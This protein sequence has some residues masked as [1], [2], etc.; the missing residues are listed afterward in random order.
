MTSLLSSI[1]GKFSTSLVLGTLF[2]VTIFVILFRL[3]VVPLIPNPPELPA[4]S[5]LV[6]SDDKWELVILSIVILVVSGLLFNLNVPHTRF[7]EGYSWLD[8]WI[9][10]WKKERYQRQLDALNAQLE[11]TTPL[12]DDLE[13]QLEQRKQE[14]IQAGRLPPPPG[15]PPD[16]D[17][18]RLEKRIE[19]VGAAEDEA[20]RKTRKGFPKR[21][22]ILPTELGNVIRS[23][24]NYPQWQYGMSAITLWP[25][26]LAAIDKEYAAGIEDVKASFDFMLNSATLAAV[27]ALSSF[28]A[29]LVYFSG[30]STAQARA[31]WAL[32]TLA[33]AIISWWFYK[34]SIGRAV[35]WGDMVR[36]AFDLYR[37]QLL[38]QLG[39]TQTV[40]TV[41]EERKLWGDI[42]RR[43][44]YGD[45]PDGAAALPGYAADESK[46]PATFAV[47]EPKLALEIIRGVTPRGAGGNLNVSIQV[48]NADESGRETRKLVLTDTV[49]DGYEYQWNSATVNHGR[50]EVEGINPY[51][52]RLSEPLR[53]G[54]PLELTY[55]IVPRGKDA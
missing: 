24:E 23:F 55:G 9:G 4:L 42:S 6:A 43:L 40:K 14:L 29:G 21:E 47:S 41:K 30:L 27:T 16:P 44:I 39:Y 18:V 15:A 54:R 31:Q 12:L 17:L 33:L 11:G 49:P 34:Q 53:P 46:T 2:P 51:S 10:N 50:L 35:A 36:A 28:A 37:V 13:G 45:P 25:R 38:K 5:A 1:S 48:R 20:I 3:I 22:S 8:T 52:F 32:E 7:Y 26:L 19:A